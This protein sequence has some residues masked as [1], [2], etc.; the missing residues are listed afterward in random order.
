METL[1]YN[2]FGNWIRKKFPFRVQKISVDAGFTC[3]NRDG[4]LSVNGCTFCDNRTF[5]PSYCSRSK[6][7]KE[8]IE[9]GKAFFA[10]KYPEMKYLAYFQSFTNTYGSVEDLKRKY[11]EALAVDDVVGIVIGT[12][13]DCV[14]EQKLD[15]IAK[16]NEECFVIVEYG[17]ESANNETLRRINRGHTFECSKEAIKRLK[18]EALSQVGI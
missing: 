8:Q 16:L 1:P 9:E 14:D 5:S 12:R 15:Y 4:R 13:P 3:P 18:K 10:R 17:I 7:I 2:D 11:E 6:S